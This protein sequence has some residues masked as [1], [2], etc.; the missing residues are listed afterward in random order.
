MQAFVA[1]A[2]PSIPLFR[3]RIPPVVTADAKQ[4]VRLIRELD[5]EDF[6][7]RTKAES[8]L[9]KQ[10]ESVRTALEQTL[11]EKPSLEVRRRITALL[12][13]L[14]PRH[15]PEQLRRLRAIEA[16]EQMRTAEARRLLETWS[17]GLPAARLTREA[18]TALE[19]RHQ[20]DRVD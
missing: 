4:T 10:G 18:K 5:S 1:D 14:D 16:V 6:A 9:A 13:Q 7:V 11:K 19:R 3:E 20:Q 8:E 17:V 12:E 15:S 2:E